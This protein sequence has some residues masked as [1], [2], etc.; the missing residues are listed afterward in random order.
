MNQRITLGVVLLYTALQIANLHAAESTLQLSSLKKDQRIAGFRV[1]NLYSD[2]AGQVVGA[3]FVHSP[4]GSPVFVLQ[5]ETVP[6]AFLW[7]NEPSNSD[8]G[9]AHSLEHLVVGKGINPFS[10][11]SGG[12]PDAM[13]GVTPQEIR[14]FHSQYYS[15]GPQTGLILA[16]APK[17]DL[18][19][20]LRKVSDVLQPFPAKHEPAANMTPGGPKYPIVPSTSTKIGIYPFP[21]KS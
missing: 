7:I 18:N 14:Q 20:F 8:E 21:S 12:V 16:L 1:A 4:S 17:N 6:Q 5:I 13:R 10:Y 9:L 11:V 3:K 19:A 15:L 2:A